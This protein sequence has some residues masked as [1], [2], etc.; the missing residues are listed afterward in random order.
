[1][2]SRTNSG[3]F[4]TGSRRFKQNSIFRI[5]ALFTGIAALCL[6]VVGSAATKG[7]SAQAAYYR[8]LQLRQALRK[9]SHRS[10]AN[11]LAVVRAYQL[12]YRIDAEYRN[13]AA[14]LE[15][16]A[17]LYA[18][19]GRDFAN[20]RYSA[21]G[22]EAYRFLM[23]QYPKSGLSRE[24]LFRIGEIYRKDIE[25]PIAARN[26]YREYLKLYPR[27]ALAADA[28]LDI[29]RINEDLS[30]RQ[31]DQ[32]HGDRQLP[33][34]DRQS[35]SG[36]AAEVESVRS[37]I[38]PD[39]TRVV[40]RTGH[41][42]KFDALQLY[43][44]PRLVFD[45]KDTHLG[46][47]LAH[48][49]FPAE[50]GFLRRIRVAQ[51]NP[52]VT[53]VVLDVP[54]IENYSV[55]S[56]P[57]PFRLVIDIRGQ[58]PL[59][60]PL[61]TTADFRSRTGF[62]PV[63]DRSAIGTPVSHKTAQAD[64]RSL[65]SSSGGASA[66]SEDGDDSV[67]VASP[68]EGLV[69][70]PPPTLTRALGLKIRRIVIDPGHGG[71]DTGTVGPAGIEEKNVVLD[72]A[73]RLRRLILRKLGCQ[74]VMTRSTD[75]FIPLEERTAIANE[76]GAD[77]F[78]SIHANASRDPGARGIETYYLNFTTNPEALAVAAREN[79]TSEQSVFQLQNLV[80][81]IA[82]SAKIGESRDFAKI[83]D[84]ELV[85]HLNED[86]D[87]QPDRGIKKAPFVVLIG[88]NMPSILVEISF[89]T[90]PRDERSLERPQFRQEIAQ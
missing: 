85:L 36:C 75:K 64:A 1:M 74:V 37:W 20:D 76:D 77:L 46:R 79:A 59:R 57:H 32:T 56:L 34:S 33:R 71:H 73:L 38:A 40:I 11:Y 30:E 54:Q 6:A 89:L 52:S 72:V 84:H 9:R 60:R 70:G 47:A 28:A 68:Q 61:A 82:L 62:R 49:S 23:A 10:L 7:T 83:V 3:V 16:A 31:V 5:L 88:A 50:H 86:G 22:I 21:K 2:R 67:A 29:A 14:A 87:P 18:E 44:P 15:G 19:A 78:I 39:Y 53:R 41:E 69:A 27:S 35:C 81:K 80:R 45:L 48:Q 55:F 26:A 24:A 17:E 13:A 65:S 58:G 25:D 66:A 63:T 42:V 43:H 12:V 8:A 51:F 90:N 4:R